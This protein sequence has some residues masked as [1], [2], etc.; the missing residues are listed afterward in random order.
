M[1]LLKDFSSP[2]QFYSNCFNKYY[3][4]GSSYSFSINKNFENL[5]DNKNFEFFTFSNFFNSSNFLNDGKI[6]FFLK[7]IRE[8][9]I[10]KYRKYY[11]FDDF[12][13]EETISDSL[14]FK[15][16]IAINLKKNGKKFMMIGSMWYYLNKNYIPK[17]LSN[18]YRFILDSKLSEKNSLVFGFLNPRRGKTK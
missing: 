12:S 8:N 14:M 6:T 5:H 17:K 1:E 2:Y 9:D 10:K 16:E 11:N 15:K 3:F 7:S 13:F 18:F 4:Q